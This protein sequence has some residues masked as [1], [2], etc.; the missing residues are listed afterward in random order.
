MN[1]WSDKSCYRKDNKTLTLYYSMEKFIFL[2]YT[3]VTKQYRILSFLSRFLQHCLN[4]ID[5]VL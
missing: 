5:T 1:E 3:Y 2:K 4:D